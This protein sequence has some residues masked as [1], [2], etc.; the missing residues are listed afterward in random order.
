MYLKLP[1]IGKWEDVLLVIGLMLI[2]YGIG[3]KLRQTT[4]KKK[5][6]VIKEENKPSVVA[7]VYKKVMIDVGGA[8][9]NPGI[10]EFKNTDRVN[11]ALLVAGGLSVEA[12]RKWVELNLNRAQ[13][14]KDGMKIYIPKTGENLG[15]KEEKKVVLAGNIISLNNASLSELESLSGVGKVLAGRIIEYREN[16]GGFKQVSELK[17]VTGIGDKLFEEIK[18]KVGL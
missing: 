16:K 9:V 13:L 12:D 8:V 11:Q 3:S 18:D 10:Y 15:L 7:E 17:Q 4:D 1:K 5:A 14:L 6:E 2:A